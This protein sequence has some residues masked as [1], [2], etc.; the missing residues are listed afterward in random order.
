M[1]AR[2]LFAIV[3]M[4]VVMFG[5]SFLTRHA[6]PAAIQVATFGGIALGFVVLHTLDAR[7]CRRER[8]G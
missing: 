1:D 8:K 3:V 6:G 4:G 5:G 2:N 7:D